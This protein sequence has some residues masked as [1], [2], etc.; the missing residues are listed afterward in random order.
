[1]FSIDGEDITFDGGNHVFDG[2]G[3]AYWDGKGSNGGVDK[4]KFL[5]VCGWQI[6]KHFFSL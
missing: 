5:R 3:Q 6:C 2:Q 4:P 1:M